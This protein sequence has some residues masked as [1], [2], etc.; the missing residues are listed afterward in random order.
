M[1]MFVNLRY[2]ID[3]KIGQGAFGM[4]FNA[5]DIKTQTPVAIKMES[6]NAPIPQVFYEGK[7][8]SLLQGKKGIPKLFWVGTEGD[9]NILV[10]EN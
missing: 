9:F 8:Y 1:A 6:V 10:I 4:I 7:I 3:K 2:K 5:V